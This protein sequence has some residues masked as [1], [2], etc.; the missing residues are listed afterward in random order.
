MEG[1]CFATVRS[2]KCKRVVLFTDLVST[3]LESGWSEIKDKSGKTVKLFYLVDT[4]D[5]ETKRAAFNT[6]SVHVIPNK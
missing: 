4:A 2:R 3:S 1:K 6:R 5:L